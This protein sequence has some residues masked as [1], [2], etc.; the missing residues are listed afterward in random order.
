MSSTPARDAPRRSVA[1]RRV[2]L[3]RNAAAS[4]ISAYVYGNVLVLA[5][6][7]PITTTRQYI[8]IAIVLGT[9]LSTFLAHVFA[10]SVSQSVRSARPLTGA[11]R[12]VELRNSVPILSSASLPCLILLTAWL[13]WLEPRTAQVLAEVAILIRIGSTVFV[14]QRLQGRPAGTTTVFAAVGLALLASVVVVVKIAL[15]H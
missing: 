14:V 2:P 13:G 10:E 5:A 11:E 3:S 4:R 8:G 6:L 9:A 15:T 7:V 12:W 1:S